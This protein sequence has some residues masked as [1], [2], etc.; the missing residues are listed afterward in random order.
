MQLET[1]LYDVQERVATITINRPEK[2]N[3]L[4]PQVIAELM[5]ALEAA[6]TDKDVGSI[7]LTGAGEKA[8]CAGNDLKWQAENGQAAVREGRKGLYGGFGGLVR[9]FDF[10][11]QINAA[12]NG[13]ALGGVF[14]IAMASDRQPRPQGPVVR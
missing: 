5:Q 6:D 1:L 4:S 13:F 12:V 2:R 8:F 10:F 9:R 14:E 3:T 11:T 7:V